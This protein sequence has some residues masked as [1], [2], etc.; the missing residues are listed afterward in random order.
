[1]K[2]NGG[3]LPLTPT[4]IVRMVQVGAAHFSRVKLTIED[5][6]RSFLVGVVAPDHR[7]NPNEPPWSTFFVIEMVSGR[8]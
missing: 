5:Q 8:G 3:E 4:D 6:E 7:P 1:M 2:P